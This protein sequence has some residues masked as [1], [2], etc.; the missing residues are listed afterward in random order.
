MLAAV[1]ML[2]GGMLKLTSAAL[3]SCLKFV[4]G[5]YAQRV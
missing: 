3:F 1:L 5:L 4:A 2:L